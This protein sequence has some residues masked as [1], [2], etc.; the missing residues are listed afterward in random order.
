MA[1]AL[2]C[3]ESGEAKVFGSAVNQDKLSQDVLSVFGQYDDEYG[4]NGQKVMGE[5]LNSM[6][7]GEFGDELRLMQRIHMQGIGAQIAA[8]DQNVVCARRLLVPAGQ[9]PLGVWTLRAMSGIKCA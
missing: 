3:I 1:A 4:F 9:Q 8:F 6:F 5:W 7:K 2:R